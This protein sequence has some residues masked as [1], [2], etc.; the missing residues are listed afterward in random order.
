MYVD[1]KKFSI[2]LAAD[3]TKQSP[4]AYVAAASLYL[5]YHVPDAA[6]ARLSILKI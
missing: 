6:S 4:S 2:P 3:L 1:L 5:V